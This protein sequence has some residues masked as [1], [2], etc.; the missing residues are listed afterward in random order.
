MYQLLII[1]L[2]II[3]TPYLSRV[4]GAEKIGIYGYTISIVTYFSIFGALGI[5]K[6]A[7]REIAYVQDNEQKRN[8]IFWELNIIKAITI[9]ISIVIYYLVFCL[10]GDF[11]IYFRILLLELSSIYLDISWYYQGMENFKRITIRNFIMRI[12]GIILIFLFVK[13]PSDLTKYI[14]IY[15][16]TNLLGNALLWINL[17]NNIRFYFPKS[18]EL[19]RHIKPIISLF[20]PQIATSI[21][22]ILDKTMLG[23]IT[24]NMS[25]VGFYEQSQKIIKVALISVTSLSIVMMPRISIN[26]AKG[27]KKEIV[28]LMK[29]SFSFDYM[30]GFA[31]AFGIM[32]ISRN[33]VPWFF[34][35]EY[36]KVSNLMFCASPIII[37]ISI[38]T[39][40]GNQYFV[41]MKKQNIQTISVICGAFVN[42]ILNICLIPSLLSLGATISTIIAEM[43]IALIEIAF[44][45]KKEK[46]KVNYIFSGFVKYCLCGFIMFCIV[47]ITGLLLKPTIINT[48]IQIIEGAIIYISLLFILKDKYIFL[49]YN[50]LKNKKGMS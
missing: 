32:G 31:I 14:L 22:T 8:K 43:I 50:K 46:F 47:F 12:L 28:N 49:V 9:T 24:Q 17:D 25:E 13:C 3:T 23:F 41:A 15:A 45:I 19:V 34:G 10:D 33:F 2:P 30:L 5:N 39:T 27:K 36:I 11:D 29:T 21:Y 42:V 35:D 48:F 1:I 37:F 18:N 20:I 6:Y 44:L 4:L 40:I 38:S 26:N 16:L 7:Q